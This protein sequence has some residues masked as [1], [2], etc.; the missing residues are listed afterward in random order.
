MAE[1]AGKEA[2][3]EAVRRFVNLARSVKVRARFAAGDQVMLAYD[4]DFPEPLGVCHTAVPMTFRDGLIASIKLF[5]DARRLEK[6]LKRDAIF[7][8]D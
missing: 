7:S 5:Y 1:L 6:N 8:Q 4:V 3:L 2:V